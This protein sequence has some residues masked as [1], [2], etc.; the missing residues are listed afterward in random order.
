MKLIINIPE[1]FEVDFNRDKFKDSLQRLIEDAHYLAG[2]YEIETAE[3]LI[4]AFEKSTTLQNWLDSFNTNSAT[5]CFEAV[6]ILK[7]RLE[8][9]DSD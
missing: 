7:E 9:E 5:K 4:K 6:N 3:M 1:V 2:N 8:D